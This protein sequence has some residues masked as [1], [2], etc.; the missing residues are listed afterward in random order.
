MG[1]SL[2]QG[3][4]RL[5]ELIDAAALNA[6][7]A[8][9]PADSSGACAGESRAS[10]LSVNGRA[11]VQLAAGCAWFEHQNPS[12]AAGWVEL[13]VRHG[14]VPAAA[15]LLQHLL[16]AYRDSPGSFRAAPGGPRPDVLQLALVY[17]QLAVRL[18]QNAAGVFMLCMNDD[19]AQPVA[20]A[21]RTAALELWG[22]L[23]EPATLQALADA[24]R[25][26]EEEVWPA[27]HAA[28]AAAAAGGSQRTQPPSYTELLAALK[29]SGVL[30]ALSAALLAAPPPC[31]EVAPGATAVDGATGAMARA[32]SQLFK[33]LQLLTMGNGP[34]QELRAV[35]E[36]LAAPD[37]QRLRWAAL[38]WLAAA[39]PT[40]AGSGVGAVGGAPGGGSGSDARGGAGGCWPL[41]QPHVIRAM[42]GRL[43]ACA[44]MLEAAISAPCAVLC[45]SQ[46]AAGAPSQDGPAQLAVMRTLLPPPRRLAALAAACARNMCGE[47]EAGLMAD[48]HLAAG[49]GG[50]SMAAGPA[51]SGGICVMLQLLTDLALVV[52]TAV[53]PDAAACLPDTVATHGWVLRAWTTA[54]VGVGAGGA[55]AG[56]EGLDRSYGTKT[57]ELVQKLGCKLAG[58]GSVS[59]ATQA[60]CVQQLL[61]TGLMHSIDSLL[62]RFLAAGLRDEAERDVA[63]TCSCTIPGLLPALLRAHI[64]TTPDGEGARGIGAKGGGWRPQDELCLLVTAAKLARREAEQPSGVP[65]TAG[66]S[67]LHLAQGL[68]MGF[69]TAAEQLSAVLAGLT[70]PPA[71]PQPRHG[72]GGD[73]TGLG[74]PAEVTPAAAVR[75]AIALAYVTAL[76]ILERAAAR[77]IAHCSGG[78]GGGSGSGSSGGSLRGDQCIRSMAAD[79]GFC[80]AS[81][82]LIVKCL[83]AV[84]QLLPPADL[85]ALQPQRTLSLLGQLLL[86]AHELQRPRARQDSSGDEA[87]GC[88][89]IATGSMSVGDLLLET[90]RMACEVAAVL[91]H[92]A[93]DAQLVG[94]VAGWLCGGVA[95][96][97]QA[98]CADL[99][100]GA[101]AAALRPWDTAAADVVTRLRTAASTSS[102]SLAAAAGT[103]SNG[104]AGTAQAMQPATAQSGGSRGCDGSR[105][106]GNAALGS[107]GGAAALLA[108]AQAE[109]PRWP[110]SVVMPRLDGPPLWPPRVLRLC[111][112]PGCRSFAGPA[113][114]DLP[115][116]KCSGCKVLRYCGA[117]CQR[118][119]WREG[120]HREACAQLKAAVREARGAE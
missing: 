4:R 24:S 72:G 88:V 42:G 96:G 35:T 75:E 100:A 43:E 17:V 47:V 50:G 97:T 32:P 27:E 3:L 112:N 29:G 52:E 22:Q 120:G 53:E 87:G 76:P 73:S 55:A 102:P 54:M 48:A 74:G 91:V 37:V 71:G 49:P 99:D 40:V 92:M 80:S 51:P 65:L 69:V 11:L 18:V 98:P 106:A 26:V 86:R 12:I 31:P 81:I 82:K 95:E 107:G 28:A 70:R 41:L 116:L 21:V 25:W 109:V 38:E 33:S 66:F 108:T 2:G 77:D 93:A 45:A 110:L 30:S 20:A 1:P 119:H 60:A 7:A 90:T 39:A 61:P 113:E 15:A 57:F 46:E 104:S 63:A 23:A 111:G 14:I 8:S 79:A 84:V 105:Q 16:R 115:L 44:N 117:G 103:Y 118:Q 64:A 78:G 58:W 36:L 101:L 10:P 9:L 62:R 59:T 83:R 89:N 68:A 114:A 56:T 85:L 6:P 34:W 5:R 13:L 19:R 67:S 94:V